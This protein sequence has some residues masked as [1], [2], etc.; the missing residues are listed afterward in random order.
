MRTATGGPVEGGFTLLEALVALAVLSAV[1]AGVFNVFSSGL[2][3]LSRSDQQL[4]LALAAESLLDRAE[5]DLAPTG[6]GDVGGVLPDGVSWRLA[7]RTYDP[8]LLRD[9][10]AV[11]EAPTRSR[12]PELGEGMF[13]PERED[14]DGGGVDASDPLGG[15][16]ARAEAAA[17]AAAPVRLRAWLLTVDVANAQGQTFSLSRLSLERAR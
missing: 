3:G 7:K 10:L 8:A 15:G 6:P 9:G 12:R 17:A 4:T 11:E 14:E 16:G 2:R 1:L 5:L 13:A